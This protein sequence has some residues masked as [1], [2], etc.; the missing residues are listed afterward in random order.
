MKDH[1]SVTENL[2]V[3]I[4]QILWLTTFSLIHVHAPVKVYP[5][6]PYTASQEEE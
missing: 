6:F 1:K 3:V 5:G 4:L 2:F